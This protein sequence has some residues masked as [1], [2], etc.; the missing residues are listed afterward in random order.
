M[1]LEI[2]LE[3]V[4]QTDLILDDGGPSDA[5]KGGVRATRAELFVGP[6]HGL[7]LADNRGSSQTATV[8]KPSTVTCPIQYSR[9]AFDSRPSQRVPDTTVSRLREYQTQV[10]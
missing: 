7:Q 8:G 6:T 3:A 1:T 10:H 9:E 2:S 5:R 4:R